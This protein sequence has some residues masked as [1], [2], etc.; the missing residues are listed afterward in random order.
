MGVRQC[1]AWV[2]AFANTASKSDVVR[3][4]TDRLRVTRDQATFPD[5]YPWSLDRALD[6]DL[7]LEAERYQ[8]L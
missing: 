6:D 8:R 4:A 5:A 3:R 7:F 2:F 1:F